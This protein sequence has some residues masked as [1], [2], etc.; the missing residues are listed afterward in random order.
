MKDKRMKQTDD[1]SKGALSTIKEKERDSRIYLAIHLTFYMAHV[2][3][4]NS[5][6]MVIKSKEDVL[7]STCGKV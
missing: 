3:A 2:S 6:A 5:Q 4:Q 1:Y 7:E